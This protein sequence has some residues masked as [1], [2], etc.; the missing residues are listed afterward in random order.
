MDSSVRVTH[1]A[2]KSDEG[3]HGSEIKWRKVAEK[4]GRDG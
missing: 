4:F 2:E 1:G 3:G